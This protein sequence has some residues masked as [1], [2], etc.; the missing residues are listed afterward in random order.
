MAL[1]ADGLMALMNDGNE[2]TV[3]AAVGSGTTSGTQTSAARVLLTL[4]TPSTASPSVI[5]VSNVPLN[6]T[7]TP[8]ASATNLLLFSASTAGT[9]YGYQA[10]TGDTA[11]NASGNFQI[12]A[13]T[14][15][16]SAV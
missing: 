13:L 16:A 14:I 1:N 9:F 12:T 5:T 7:G 3:Y 6:F 10:L 8:A 15:T 4:G 11:F 2:A